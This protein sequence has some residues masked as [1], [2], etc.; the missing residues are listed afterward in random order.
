MCSQKTV[1]ELF[2]E[3]NMFVLHIMYS[4]TVEQ[5]LLM[6]RLVARKELFFW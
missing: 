3:Y 6:P 5:I 2:Q 4:K 1:N